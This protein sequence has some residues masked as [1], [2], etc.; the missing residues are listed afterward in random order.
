MVSLSTGVIIGSAFNNIVT[1]FTKGVV[2]PILA[3]IG[4]S[5]LGTSH[6]K[7]RIWER[8][9]TVTEKVN[10]VEVKTEK[11]MPVLLDVG[12]V[13]GAVVGFLITATIVFFI[14]VKPTNKLLDLMLKKEQP[15]A[16]MPPDVALL[17][18]IRDMMQRQEERGLK[19]AV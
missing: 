13:M 5:D 2:E 17:T 8:M 14:I 3:I 12:S 7:F 1:A 11:L 4:G 15:P 10:G 9:T 6:L 18:E 16:A 19:G